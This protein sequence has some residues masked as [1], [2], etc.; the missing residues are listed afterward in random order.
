M[1][2]VAAPTSG[3]RLR[4]ADELRDWRALRMLLPDA[5]HHGCGC[6]AF[7]AVSEESPDFLIGAIAVTPLM[8]IQPRLGPRVAPHVIPPWRRRGVGKAL[9]DV[10]AHLATARKAEALYAWNKVSLDSN[11]AIAWRALGFDHAIESSLTYIDADRTIETLQPLFDWLKKGGHIPS[12]ARM[13]SLQDVDPDQVVELVTTCLAGAGAEVALKQ[14][15]IGQ[16]PKPLEP[17]LSKVL[18]Y[19]DRVVGAMLARPFNENVGLVEVNVLHPLLRYGW[20]NVW[21]KLE[22]TRGARDAG[23]SK[24]LYETNEQ[25]VDTMRLTSRLGG[26]VVTRVELYRLIPSDHR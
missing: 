26:E 23:Y 4:R 9:V 2:F 10:A 18:L 21:L 12:E 8:Q 11:A 13:A 25:H 22:T 6:D 1:A 14:R 15:L 16:H 5:I 7:V 20:A 19:R 17:V 24:F 3:F